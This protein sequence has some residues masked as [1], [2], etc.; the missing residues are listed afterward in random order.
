ME[1]A[2]LLDEDIAL[3]YF[4]FKLTFEVCHFVTFLCVN[5]L[6]SSSAQVQIKI[7]WSGEANA[8]FPPPQILSCFKISSTRLVA[9]P[10]EAEWGH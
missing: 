5:S 7:L 10:C 3:V 2:P 8:K 9:L 6:T 1:F 4:K